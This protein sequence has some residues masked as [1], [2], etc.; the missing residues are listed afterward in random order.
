MT[1]IFFLSRLWETHNFWVSFFLRCFTASW[2]D[3]RNVYKKSVDFLCFLWDL[4]WFRIP[5][6]WNLGHL[7][8]SNFWDSGNP[9]PETPV[10]RNRSAG[11]PWDFWENFGDWDPGT[12]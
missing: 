9:R 6:I 2:K 5:E 7:C 10:H 12:L 1:E 3:L 8:I 11:C 4:I